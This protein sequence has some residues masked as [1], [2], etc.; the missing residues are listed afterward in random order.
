MRALCALLLL[1]AVEVSAQTFNPLV[2]PVTNRFKVGVCYL[3]IISE[4]QIP[5][6]EKESFSKFVQEETDKVIN[7]VRSSMGEAGFND[8]DIVL[9]N[10][11]CNIEDDKAGG[12]TALLIFAMS[13]Q[14]SG[15]DRIGINVFIK[16]PHEKRMVL[17][18]KEGEGMATINWSQ[19]DATSIIAAAVRD[20]KTAKSRSIPSTDKTD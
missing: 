11:K 15:E 9:L 20:I 19:D 7:Q 18:R 8:V 6:L 10:K 16:S 4:K 2:L 13:A 14:V 5:T 12:V 3:R 1:S 17:I